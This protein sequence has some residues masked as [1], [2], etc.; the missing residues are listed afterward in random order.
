MSQSLD[1]E[2]LKDASRL[3]NN[4][5]KVQLTYNINNTQRAIGSYLSSVITR[6]FG[7][8]TLED[9]HLSIRL[10]GSAGQSLGAFSVKGNYF[11]SVW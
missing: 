6:K 7:M 9:N 3:F 2:I 4:K 5:E 10:R 8:H 11:R 1:F